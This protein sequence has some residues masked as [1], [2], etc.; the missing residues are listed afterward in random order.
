[1]SQKRLAFSTLLAE[2]ADI[3]TVQALMRHSSPRLT[4]GLYM[5]AIDEKK[6]SAQSKVI[7]M[8]RPREKRAAEG[9]A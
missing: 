5:H 8:V 9:R 6:R 3:E 7:E 4:L 2:H 1:V